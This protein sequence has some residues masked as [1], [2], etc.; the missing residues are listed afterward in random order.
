MSRVAISLVPDADFEFRLLVLVSISH[1]SHS[2]SGQKASPGED[3]VTQLLRAVRS[4]RTTIPSR[5]YSLA[6]HTSFFAGS[7]PRDR[8]GRVSRKSVTVKSLNT[9]REP[10]VEGWDDE[11]PRNGAGVA[12]LGDDRERQKEFLESLRSPGLNIEEENEDEEQPAPVGAGG[13]GLGPGQDHY[14]EE[15]DE[16][17]MNDWSQAQDVVE[18]MVGLR[19]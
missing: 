7:A 6:R 19:G 9:Q 14:E 2:S 16:D 4:P 10:S 11:T 13:W 18:R 12:G 1:P 5:A 3:A 8:R 17:T 15:D